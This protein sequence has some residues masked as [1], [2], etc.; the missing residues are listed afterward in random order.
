[1]RFNSRFFYV[2]PLVLAACGGVTGTSASSSS[3]A[4]SQD[5]PVAAAGA[6]SEA[7][8]TSSAL[9]LQGLLDFTR[10]AERVR[11]PSPGALRCD[12]S[13][14]ITTATVC[15]K[16]V[17]ATAHYE[18]TSCARKGHRG[19][20]G[21]CAPSPDGRRGPSGATGR[22]NEQPSSAPVEGFA[23]STGTVDIAVTATAP[24]TCDD[25][26][27]ITFD[28]TATFDITHSAKDGAS[29][30]VKGEVKASS[31]RLASSRR[32][33]SR[34]S[35]LDI[36]HERKDAA[37][38]VAQS[39]HLSGTTDMTSDEAATPPTRTLSGALT[40]E[41]LKDGATTSGTLE[42]DGIVRVPP[43][44]CFWPIAGTITKTTATGATQTLEFSATCGTATLDGTEIDLSALVPKR[45]EHG[46]DRPGDDKGGDDKGGDDKGGE[47]DRARREGK[48]D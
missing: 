21:R 7:S 40:Y 36:T 19:E 20:P 13:P 45:G 17:P 12:E 37:G 44:T 43:D 4:L 32:A 9:E 23:E 41:D 11:E 31:V 18:W 26:T 33:V 30:S 28:K 15:G 48:R 38:A 24:E 5:T 14:E 42:I 16:E 8:D 39:L 6:L 22:T 1:M 3:S 34:A 10:L 47:R 2:T 27:Q 35:T 25:T 29:S 46:D